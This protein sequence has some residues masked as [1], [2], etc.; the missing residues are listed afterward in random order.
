MEP[1]KQQSKD[2]NVAI[3]PLGNNNFHQYALMLRVSNAYNNPSK[4]IS[5]LKYLKAKIH[6]FVKNARQKSKLR[7]GLQSKNIPKI[8]YL[9]SKDLSTMNSMKVE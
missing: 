5:P 2:K 4:S 6:I 8:W 9:S 7:R 1:W 3:F